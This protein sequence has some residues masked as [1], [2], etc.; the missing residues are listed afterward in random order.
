MNS[1]NIKDMRLMFEILSKDYQ[2]LASDMKAMGE[3]LRPIELE[4]RN[5]EV[6]NVEH[7]E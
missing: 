7:I 4:F 2:R 6:A 1:E 5:K 3:Y